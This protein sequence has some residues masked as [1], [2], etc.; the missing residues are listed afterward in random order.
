MKI[1]KKERE[2]ITFYSF[3]KRRIKRNLNLPSK[4]NKK[5]QPMLL[6]NNNSFL[7]LQLNI[8]KQR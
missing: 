3:L 8:H 5:I 7:C 1:I 6:R 4:K 2:I